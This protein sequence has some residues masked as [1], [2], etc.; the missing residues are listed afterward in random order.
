MGFSDAGMALDTP[1]SEE[2]FSPEKLL[3]SLDGTFP[4][5]VRGQVLGVE[6]PDEKEFCEF[7]LRKFPPEVAASTVWEK[8]Q[9]WE[10]KLFWSQVL[11]MDANVFS[12]VWVGA[13]P[14]GRCA[15][16][17]GKLN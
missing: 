16:S 5:V 8:L 9:F 6:E 10:F 17:P 4:P 13:D 15:P 7:S 1:P 11:P 3:G 12:G 2:K 14:E